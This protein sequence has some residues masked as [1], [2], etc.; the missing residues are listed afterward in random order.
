MQSMGVDLGEA[1]IHS[2]SRLPVVIDEYMGW[3]AR[4][5]TAVAYLRSEAVYS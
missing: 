5:Q 1:M 2:I 3:Q 4:K